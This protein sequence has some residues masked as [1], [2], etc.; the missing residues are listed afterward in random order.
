MATLTMG[1]TAQTSLTTIQWSPT[2][3]EVLPADMATIKNMI[4][5]DLNP[6][7]ISPMGWIDYNGLL[8]IP[9]RGQIR[10]FRG[11]F[12]GVDAATGWPILV[13][14]KAAA[15]NPQWVHTGSAYT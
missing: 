11:D 2:P 5:D 8:M 14:A 4:K 6:S 1:T 7:S 3:S 15:N 13:S 9:R 12:I 10:V